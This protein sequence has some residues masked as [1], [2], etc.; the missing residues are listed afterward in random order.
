[1]YLTPKILFNYP[2]KLQ[3]NELSFNIKFLKNFCFTEG[4]KVKKVPIMDQN[5]YE[6]HFLELNLFSKSK[7][8][9]CLLQQI[10]TEDIEKYF[11]FGIKFDDFY[12]KNSKVDQAKYIFIY[13]KTFLFISNNPLCSLFEIIFQHILNIK[14]LN[15]YKNLCIYDLINVKE[16]KTNFERENEERVKIN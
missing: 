2:N 10:T 9:F 8:S 1:M 6:Q 11:I 7:L 15:L 14:K 13:E 16:C 4:V 12:I 5:D 3:E